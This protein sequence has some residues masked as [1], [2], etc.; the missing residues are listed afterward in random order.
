MSTTLR[1]P[2]SSDRPPG[3]ANAGRL[4]RQALWDWLGVGSFASLF[5]CYSIATQSLTL[6]STKGGWA[7]G[8]LTTFSP[9]TLMVAVSATV[10]TGWAGQLSLGQFAFVAVGAYLTAF[11]FGPQITAFLSKVPSLFGH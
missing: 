9:R 11:I 7:Y 2:A 5:A 3:T 10:L 8:Y 6:G 1:S 4:S